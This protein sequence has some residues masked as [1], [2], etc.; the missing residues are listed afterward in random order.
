VVQ[1]AIEP[2][3]EIEAAP[4]DAQVATTQQRPV[5][6][7]TPRQP[8]PR[9]TP[10]AGSDT[11]P[12]PVAVKSDPPT[13]SDCDETGCVLEKYARPCCA[14]FKPAGDAFQPGN[15]ESLEKPQIRAGVDK[16]KPKVIACGEQFKAKGTVKLALTVDG[17]GNVQD[18]SVQATP[19]DALGNCVAAVL[20]KA[21]FA[22]TTNGGSFTYP[23]VF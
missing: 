5:K 21:H 14:K 6:P 13:E 1:P 8:K 4:P 10:K 7:R 16:V 9:V 18:L 11:S 15:G 3:I 20:R 17:E 12:Q 19:D 23:F 22:K 2:E